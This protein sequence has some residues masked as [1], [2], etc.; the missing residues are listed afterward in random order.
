MKLIATFL[1]S[2]TLLV[3]QEIPNARQHY[4]DASKSQKN[5]DEFYSLMENYN[6]D[7]KVLLAYKGASIALK[8]RYTKQIKQKKSFFIEGVKLLEDAL[9]NDPNN[10]EIR[11][12]RLSIQEN[13]PKILNYK[14]NID[15]DK[16]LLLSSFYKQNQSLKEYIKNYILQ[17]T[18][19]T[20]KEKKSILN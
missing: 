6:K 3:C 1:L 14:N 18:G 20:D 2:I 9:K 5:T 8:A 4:I 12:I 15:E 10:L 13:T 17:S 7:N 16:R 11:L 19:F